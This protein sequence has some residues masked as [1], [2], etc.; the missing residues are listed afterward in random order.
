MWQHRLFD[1]RT[2]QTTDGR[3]V[4]IDFPGIPNHDG[5][6]DF[7]EA[8]IRI[9][10]TLYR[11]EVEL[12]LDADDWTS[13]RHHL[14]PHYNS[15]IL[16]VALTPSST[17]SR[18][19]ARRIL[20]LLILLPGAPGIP[21]STT[22]IPFPPHPI[23][24]VPPAGTMVPPALS[25]NWLAQLG[26][27]RLELKVWA[28]E[29]RLCQLIEEESE[30]KDIGYSQERPVSPEALLRSDAIKEF[31]SAGAWKQ[32]LYEGILDGLGY[33]KNRVPF[34]ALAGNLRLSIVEEFGLDQTPTIMA[35]MFGAA[36]LLPAPGAIREPESRRYVRQL[37]RLWRELSPQVR[38]PLLHQAQWQFFRLRPINF[39]SARLASLAFL[40]PQLFGEGALRRLMHVFSDPV[41]S[42]VARHQLL[43]EVFRFVP[44]SFWAR[45]L[46]FEKSHNHRGIALGKSR[47]NDII[48][49]TLI[50]FA[51]LYSR[52][53]A[54]HA[55]ENNTI[56]LYRTF[57]PLQR[58]TITVEI[59]RRILHGGAEL[60]SGRLH[61]GALHLYH[62]YCRAVRCGECR[63][64]GLCSACDV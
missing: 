24:A 32:L 7:L 22:T 29:T 12:H 63:I 37:R 59:E 8:R 6:P 5:G 2:L 41:L 23:P 31:R 28:M 9:G 53:F 48:I 3:P 1:T 35:L 49:N 52:I 62:N 19:F 42:P 55:I 25:V 20:P 54:Q 60:S 47:I 45:H 40:L 50:P 16:H 21:E 18:T 27:K 43:R 14:D 11:G 44:D 57:P 39:P 51:L 64:A 61:Q 17:P 34:R 56:L 10:P 30:L 4:V 58:N 26:M 36:G 46:Y 15:V 13:H 33:S 38:I